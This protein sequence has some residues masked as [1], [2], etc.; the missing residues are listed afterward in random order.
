MKNRSTKDIQQGVTIEQR[1]F[2]EKQFFLT[3]PWSG[4][5]RERVGIP[6]LKHF[7]GKLLYDHI[8]SEFPTLVQE[9]KNMVVDA[10]TQLDILGPSRQTFVEQRQFLTRLAVRYQRSVTD[11]L[12]GNYNDTW[13]P[14]DPRKLRMHLQITNEAFS[15]R[16]TQRG[17]TR[18]FRLVDGEIDKEFA[19]FLRKDE[20][21]IYVWIRRV[22]RE[23]RGSELPGTV[24]PTLLENM[25]RQQS[26]KW[27]EIATKHVAD[28]ETI[29]SRFNKAVFQDIFHEDALRDKL[30]HRNNVPFRKATQD[31]AIQ[32][33]SIIA[34]EREGILQTVNHYFADTLAATRQDRV[35]KR[36][37]KLGLQ[38]GRDITVDLKS[39]ANTAHLSNEDQA[40]NDIHDI[41]KAYYKVALK[42]FTDNVVIQVIERYYL[43]LEGPVKSIS[44][45]Y[46][47]GLSDA[48]LSHL[49][50]EN[51]A[52]SS[53]RNDVNA[54]LERLEKALAIAEKERS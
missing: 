18:G 46:V 6:A 15:K 50:A 22:Y 32:L 44:A 38:D 48:D 26:K 53:N 10:R 13:E 25:F 3:S 27:S 9:I 36:L 49:A 29:V 11:G 42:R 24:N 1:H 33:A 34:D 30:E 28:I 54:K 12:V 17:H 45:E 4:L 20:E 8:R 23:S 14:D 31:A 21:N 35:L 51:Y 16:M 43:R 39:L 52:T 47:G 37:Q 5:S 2:K 19:P 41:L 7:L 40:V